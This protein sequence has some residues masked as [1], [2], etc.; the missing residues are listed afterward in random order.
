MAPDH[1]RSGAAHDETA[2]DEEAHDE[3]AHEEA[4]STDAPPVTPHPD[5]WA[6]LHERADGAHAE[7]I[8]PE[9]NLRADPDPPD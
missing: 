9:A 7:Q 2:H 8:L 1:E 5:R 4:R 6:D 3:D